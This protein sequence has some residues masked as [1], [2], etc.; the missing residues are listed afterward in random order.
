MERAFSLFE[1]M[2]VCVII[3]ILMMIAIPGY[4]HNIAKQRQ[5]HAI[6]TLMQMAHA[7]EEAR[8]ASGG[9]YPQMLIS[10]LM[11][12]H[13]GLGYRYEITSLKPTQFMLSAIPDA[14]QGSLLSHKRCKTLWINQAGQHCW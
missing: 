14:H 13:T 5:D 7:L 2:I 1:C 8:L 11:P 4:Q 3:G 9:A 6:L 10:S 12:A